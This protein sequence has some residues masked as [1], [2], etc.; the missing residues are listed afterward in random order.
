M[1]GSFGCTLEKRAERY[2]RL[3]E[4][5]GAPVS[6]GPHRCPRCPRHPRRPHLPLRSSSTVD[7]A[8]AH[9]TTLPRADASGWSAV[10]LRPSG[11]A[12]DGDKPYPLADSMISSKGT[13]SP[14]SPQ[15]RFRAD[16]DLPE[17]LW[18]ADLLCLTTFPP[19]S[20]RRRRQQLTRVWSHVAASPAGP[21]TRTTDA[22]CR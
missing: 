15:P 19:S 14:T 20:V 3:R 7:A 8:T 10:E 22:Q 1:R 12:F 16:P 17:S 21:Y 18:T 4:G 6:S 2:K 11:A 13:L 9:D 5:R